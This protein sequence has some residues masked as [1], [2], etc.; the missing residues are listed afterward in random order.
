MEKGKSIRKARSSNIELLRILAAFGV[1][2]RHYDDGG[3]FLG[4]SKYFV[5][6]MCDC[7]FAWV[8]T[9]F[10]MISGY[11]TFRRMEVDWKKPIKLYV[12]LVFFQVFGVVVTALWKREFAPGDLLMCLVPINY[13]FCQFI[14]VSLISPYL[15]RLSASLDQDR[16]RKLLLF[17]VG[18]F[19]LWGYGMDLLSVPLNAN[20]GMATPLSISGNIY[21]Y[22][23]VNFT[24]CYLI[25]AYIGDGTLQIRKPLLCFAGSTAAILVIRK[26]CGVTIASAFCSPFV[27]L[28]T[29]SIL[30]LFLS[31]DLGSIKWINRLASAGFTVYLTHL[32]LMAFV[33]REAYYDAPTVKMCMHLA[34]SVIAL[35]LGG[36]LLNEVY[37]FLTE[38]VFRRIWKTDK[39]KAN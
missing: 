33:G 20:L 26:L 31:W 38:P 5:F 28:Q 8:V 35:Y 24:L 6:D 11:C 18:I 9:A 13:F 12:Q 3:H 15:N 30:C 19:S 39:Q 37:V 7:F 34:F 4:V 22:N 14:A 1:I 21:G 32:V 29:A 10:F 2:A 23:V 27:L 16:K 36:F 25:G 17:L